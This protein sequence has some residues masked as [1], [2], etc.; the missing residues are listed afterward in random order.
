MKIFLCGYPSA[1]GGAC[2][3]AWHTV[4]L[5]REHG[6]EVTAIPT[7]IAD[8]HWRRKMDAIGAETIQT[9]PRN[10]PEM[11]PGVPGLKGSI[12]LSFCNGN[13]LKQANTFRTLG[14]RIIWVNCMTYLF[15]AEKKH[16]AKYG[17]TFDRYVFQS[18]YQKSILEP[19]LRGFGYKP[20]NG[21]LIRGAFDVNEFPL[22][23]ADQN[24]GDP[25]TIGRISRAAPDK[26]SAN[27][28]AIYSRI[29]RM[30]RQ[31]MRARVMAW[32]KQVQNK[33][34]EAGRHNVR[35]EC[36][37]SDA[38]SAQTFLSKLHCLHQWNGGAGE[39]WPRS[40]LEAM[41]AGVPLI[42]Q[43]KWGWR[44]MVR[45][46]ETGFLCESDEESEYFAAKLAYE[47]Q[48]R[49]S[50]IVAAREQVEQEHANKEKIWEGWKALLESMQ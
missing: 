29:G 42:V 13:F 50:I 49:M 3:E 44:E 28:W 40:G 19:Q 26:Y 30:I 38:E 31:P 4:K 8:S 27:M 41:S 37:K 34:G 35:A 12:V 9:L 46:Q 24:N 5:L 36:L 23:P 39:N 33:C 43:A 21:H 15:V 18:H 32:S 47:P 22:N 25:F 45:H 10:G 14:C 11:L 48:Y 16:Y 7:W 1:V 20:E 17:S 6:V 2:T